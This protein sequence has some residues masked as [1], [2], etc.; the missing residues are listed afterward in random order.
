MNQLASLTIEPKK[1][2]LLPLLSTQPFLVTVEINGF[3]TL[4]DFRICKWSDPL[5]IMPEC[6]NRIKIIHGL[7]QSAI[8]T[9]DSSAIVAQQPT[10]KKEEIDV[11]E[12]CCCLQ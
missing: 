7:K 8:M 1:T 3:E 12:Y 9:Q 2:T 6:D 5:I 10:F 11:D 4:K